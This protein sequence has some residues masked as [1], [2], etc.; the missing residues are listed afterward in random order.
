MSLSRGLT[1]VCISGLSACIAGV[2]V[3][4]VSMTLA[5]VMVSILL[6]TGNTGNSV[7]RGIYGGCF[8]DRKDVFVCIGGTTNTHGQ[9]FVK[10]MANLLVKV[11]NRPIIEIRFPNALIVFNSRTVVVPPSATMWIPRALLRLAW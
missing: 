8:G 11:A 3:P 1:G 7:T 6:L 4:P 5:C 2:E 10:S 9:N